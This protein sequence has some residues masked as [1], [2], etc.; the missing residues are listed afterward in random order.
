MR[1]LDKKK[2]SYQVH[3]Y[4]W[5]EDQNDTDKSV[6]TLDVDMDRIFKTLVLVGNVTG[7]LVTAIPANKELDLK[8]VAKA[9]GNKKVDM[10]HMKDLEETTGYIRGGCSPI[11][12]K[13]SFPTYLA[14]EA[15]S[16]DTIV[17][18]AGKRGMQVEIT[19]DE[20][21]MMTNGKLAEITSKL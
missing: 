13:K 5:S 9:S 7:P 12:M 19:P 6:A 21:L 10:L 4:A 17:V 20:L 15:K 2:I 14:D 8:T 11:G 1:Q 16:L 3:E 18:S